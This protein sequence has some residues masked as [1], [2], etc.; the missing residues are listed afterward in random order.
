M[1]GPEKKPVQTPRLPGS[2]SFEATMPPGA[3]GEF[4]TLFVFWQV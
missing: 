1:K 4:E 2:V 3:S